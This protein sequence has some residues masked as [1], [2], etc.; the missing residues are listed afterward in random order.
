MR[1]FIA[2]D[3]DETIKQQLA[4]L[5]ARL[6][7]RCPPLKWVD[8]RQIHVTLKFLGEIADR[9]VAP[10]AKALDELCSQCQPVDIGVE[11]L[12]AFNPTG[13]VKVLWVG[14]QE[15]TGRLAQCHARCEEL[16]A[17]L[18]FLPEG[19]KFSPHLT[20]ARNHDVR[21]SREIRSVLDAEPPFHAGT[22]TIT[23][24]TFYQSTLTPKGPIYAAL[25]RHSFKG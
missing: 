1:T 3:L 12:G 18:G 14:L 20:L 5:Q 4:A 17:P 9:Q 22:Q 10:I 21:N 11:S 7:P 16:L 6:Q 8:A 23:G 15:S 25:S 13:V 19:R 24:V 2:L